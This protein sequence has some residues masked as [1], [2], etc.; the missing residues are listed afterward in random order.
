M[1][2]FEYVCMD[3]G[4]EFEKVVPTS[5]TAVACAKCASPK[6]EKKLSVFA[7]AGSTSN[8]AGFDAPGCGTC[9]ADEP[10][11]CGMS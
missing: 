8:E 2:L 9:G 10:G 6:V 4:A 7:V 3:C 5:K 11:M 1:P